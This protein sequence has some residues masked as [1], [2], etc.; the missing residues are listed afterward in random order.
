MAH[1]TYPSGYL[2][3]ASEEERLAVLPPAPIATSRQGTDP[4]IS[5]PAAEPV[6]GG[7]SAGGVVNRMLGGT[8]DDVTLSEDP[9]S[10]T[11]GGAGAGNVMEGDG[12]ELQVTPSGLYPDPSSNALVV[13]TNDEKYD[14]GFEGLLMRGA[15][16]KKAGRGSHSGTAV[17][18]GATIK[19]TKERPKFSMVSLTLWHH[20]CSQ[21]IIR[22]VYLDGK[23]NLP[24]RGKGSEGKGS[25]TINDPMDAQSCT[26]LR[27]FSA[28]WLQVT[29]KYWKCSGCLDETFETLNG[30]YLVCA[31]DLRKIPAEDKGLHGMNEMFCS[32]C[33]WTP[34]RVRKCEPDNWGQNKLLALQELKQ[35]EKAIGYLR[36][37]YNHPA[38]KRIIQFIN[39]KF[40]L[41]LPDTAEGLTEFLLK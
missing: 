41:E 10:V 26:T 9:Q 6:G 40:G 12:A 17:P 21:M 3:N 38:E 19:P 15:V 39:A 23:T 30:P 7:F 25:F 31:F 34:D 2:P 13:G 33:K 32:N 27:G 36:K 24:N 14:T 1:H 35:N 22:N 28:C 8:G 29:G 37:C 16:W 18:A 20:L 4:L 11:A 5:Y